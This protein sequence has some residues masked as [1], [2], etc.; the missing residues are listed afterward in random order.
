MT[1]QEGNLLIMW[2]AVKTSSTCGFGWPLSGRTIF[3]IPA[4]KVWGKCE[5]GYPGGGGAILFNIGWGG[6]TEDLCGK[7][8]LNPMWFSP[9]SKSGH[10]LG[11][12]TVMFSRALS[13]EYC[14]QVF[15]HLDH[16]NAIKYS[17][18]GVNKKAKSVFELFLFV[19][20]EVCTKEIS[21]QCVAFWSGIIQITLH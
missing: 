12:E 4:Q 17:H 13:W 8:K 1:S 2:A 11:L 19:G 18:D 9:V 14:D 10:S 15:Y 21:S 3:A 5:R 6:A 7:T 20:H 16:C